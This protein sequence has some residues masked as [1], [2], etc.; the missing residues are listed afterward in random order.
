MSDKISTLGKI[1]LILVMILSALGIITNLLAVGS[2]IIYLVSALMCGLELFGLIYL[3]KG[4]GITYLYLYGVGYIV[5]AI[6]T[7]VMTADKTTSYYVGF[8]I[9]IAIN[10]GLTYLACKKTF[11]K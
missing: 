4:K 7:L 5:N 6:I 2:G 9:G 1:W 11:N 10:I 8:V 3:I